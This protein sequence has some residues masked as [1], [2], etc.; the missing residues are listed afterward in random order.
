MGE[1]VPPKLGGETIT[2]GL[3]GGITWPGMSIN[4]INN[5]L[6]VPVNKIPYSLKVELKTHSTLV[7]NSDDIDL[8]LNKVSL[9][10]LGFAI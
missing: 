8:Y 3:H 9:F 7:P 6:F 5:L 1:F 4:P 10:T 2:M